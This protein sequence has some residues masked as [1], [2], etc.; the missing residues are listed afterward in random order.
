VSLAT[1]SL[2]RGDRAAADPRCLYDQS[3][4]MV[5]GLAVAAALDSDTAVLGAT[6]STRSCRTRFAFTRPRSVSSFAAST[7]VLP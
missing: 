3:V 6:P 1:V 7:S 4:A 2:S 5:Q